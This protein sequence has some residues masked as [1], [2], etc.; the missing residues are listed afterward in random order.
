MKKKLFIQLCIVILILFVSYSHAAADS[1]EWTNLY[2]GPFT[3]YSS[4][5]N[6]WLI[7]YENYPQETHTVT[8]WNDG[9]TNENF[10][11]AIFVLNEVY[12]N[13]YLSWDQANGYFTDGTDIL[14][15]GSYD[16]LFDNS[17]GRVANL[18]FGIWPYFDMG[19]L[20]A[21]GNMESCTFTIDGDYIYLEGDT[22]AHVTAVP[23]PM[24][25]FLFLSGL[26]G[27]M[28]VKIKR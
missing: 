5:K 19:D 16:G 10:L 24:T 2:N 26:A 15:L 20:N 23:E 3:N 6:H 4:F 22:L 12:V 21:S 25:I 27:L 8:T 9:T 17:E 7:S 18:N 14:Y 13:N 28:G 11:D 1:V